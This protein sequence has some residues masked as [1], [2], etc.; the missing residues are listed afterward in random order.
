MDL[1]RAINRYM[2]RSK[3]LIGL[4]WGEPT[5]KTNYIITVLKTVT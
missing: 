1:I 4:L 3:V 5:P 2:L